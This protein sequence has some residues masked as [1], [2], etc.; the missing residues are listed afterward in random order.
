MRNKGV[1]RE[2][3]EQKIVGTRE[4]KKV[5]RWREGGKES[6]V[7]VGRKKEKEEGTWEKV[8]WREGGREECERDVMKGD[9]GSNGKEWFTAVREEMKKRKERRNEEEEGKKKKSE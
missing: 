9:A 7:E 1:V 2:L 6:E 8:M 4:L 5:E 3:R